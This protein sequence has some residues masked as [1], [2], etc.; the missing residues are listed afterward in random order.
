[1]SRTVYVIKNNVAVDAILVPDDAEVTSEAVVI[2]PATFTPGDGDSYFESASGGIGWT[3]KDGTLLPPPLPPIDLSAL[4]ASLCLLIDEAAETERAKH[5]TPGSGQAMT[6][7]AKA[8]EALA[9]ETDSSPSEVNYPLL[10]AEVGITGQDLPAVGE[11]VRA[12]YA[13]W[14]AIGAAIER[15]RLG[16]KAAVMAATSEGAVRAAAAVQWPT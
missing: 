11:A 13:Q 8:A 5:I 15:A 4:K 7:Q 3:L 9:L 12:A 14:L 16:A 2:G 10:S 6:Y 1:M